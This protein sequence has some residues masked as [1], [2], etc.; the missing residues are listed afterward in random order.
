ME[1][2]LKNPIRFT[3][4]TGLYIT[5]QDTPQLMSDNEYFGKV[6]GFGSKT[7]TINL[8]GCLLFATA[9]AISSATE[10]Y[11]NPLTLNTD[12]T[13]F[14]PNSSD[15]DR[16]RIFNFARSKGLIPDYWTR[17]RQGDLTNRIIQLNS[18]QNKGYSIEAQIPVS[19]GGKP[20][21][22]WVGINGIHYFNGKAWGKVATSSS[23]DLQK[24]DRLGPT[25][26]VVNGEN[27]TKTA[28]IDLS[29]IKQIYDFTKATPNS[30][31]VQS[32]K[33]V[34]VV[35]GA[36]PIVKPNP[37]GSFF[38]GLFGGGK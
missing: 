26:K 18:D 31:Q 24:E 12:K 37:I 6:L 7:D 29:A 1:S 34:D 25:W 4:P 10:T 11:V 13:F 28:Y 9:H 36:D 27:G 21:D 33:N 20:E 8:Y 35:A 23:H 3:D 15:T 38:S 2:K 32:D 19:W 14:E 16:G 22:H 30:P 5:F 17:A